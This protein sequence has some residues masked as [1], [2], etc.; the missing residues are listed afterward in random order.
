M[1]ITEYDR[2]ASI[3]RRPWP[4]RGCCAMKNNARPLR[5]NFHC[6]AGT[7]FHLWIRLNFT[8]ITKYLYKI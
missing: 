3:M 2:E 6:V 8:K 1:C 5:E 7:I 4:I